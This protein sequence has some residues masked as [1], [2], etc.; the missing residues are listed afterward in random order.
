VQTLVNMQRRNFGFDQSNLLLFGLDATREGVQGQRLA[1]FYRQALERIRAL[2]GVQ[3]A[4]MLEYPPF[5]GVSNNTTIQI[6]G[7][8]RNFDNQ[9]VRFFT[10]APG[11][12]DAM[13]IPLL[14][15]RGIAETDTAASLKIAVVNDL[16][17]QTFF[18]GK[19][20]IGQQIKGPSDV[21][22]FQ[23]VGV[24]KDVELTDVHAGPMPKAY[25]SYVQMPDMLTSMYFEVRFAGA[26]TS[27]LPEVR[28]VIRQM[29]SRLPLLHVRTQ[30]E[31]TQAQFTQEQLFARLSSFF[32]LLALLLAMIGLYG[33][34]AYAVTRKT[35][36][37]GI[38]IAL[39]A[40]P[41]DVLRMVLGQGIKLSA[42]GISIGF[43]VALGVTRL[44]RTLI[45]GVTATDPLTFAS[46]ALLLAVVAL[47][48]CYIPARRAMRVDPM[49]ALRYE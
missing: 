31:Q 2:P 9:V 1:D 15:G 43:L 5:S 42:I 14:L 36:E 8:K 30:Q 40:R 4:T 47:A 33:T 45:F 32:G 28:D 41:A 49:I 37:I 20:P 21:I 16:F 26:A 22:S 10:V 25:L 48:A 23:I 7:S 46:V 38:R 6:V 39:G 24:V 35:R 18:D 11:F 29:D 34:M 13:R 17:V 3:S 27:V 19:S 44:V 12:F